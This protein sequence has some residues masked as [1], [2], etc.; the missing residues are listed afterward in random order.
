[1]CR[2]REGAAATIA[3]TAADHHHL[4]PDFVCVSFNAWQNGNEQQQMNV[5]KNVWRHDD[6]WRR[7]K[8]TKTTGKR[9]YESNS[10]ISMGIRKMR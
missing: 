6:E 2:R 7:S 10:G 5:D 1:M 4:L 8:P 3:T 9:I